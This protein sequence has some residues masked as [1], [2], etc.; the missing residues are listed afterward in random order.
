MLVIVKALV[1][2][3]LERKL[4]TSEKVDFQTNALHWN[5][6]CDKTHSFLDEILQIQVHLYLLDLFLVRDLVHKFSISI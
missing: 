5:L 3:G 1:T 4:Q 2:P 6:R